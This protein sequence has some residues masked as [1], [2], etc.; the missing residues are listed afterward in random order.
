MT[1]ICHFWYIPVHIHI[2][3][4]RSVQEFGFFPDCVSYKTDLVIILD[5]STSVSGTNFETMKGFAADLLENADIDSGHV[6]VG[7]LLYSTEVSIQFY[8]REY[9][10]KSE[11]VEAISRIPYIRGST[12]TADALRT[13]WTRMFTA[14]YGDRPDAINVAVLI[15]DGLSNINS[16]RTLIEANTAKTK[17]IHIYSIGIGLEDT[18][19]ISAIATVPAAKNVFTINDFREL[20][21]LKKDVLKS[22]CLGI[23]KHI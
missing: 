15:T 19:E 12:N 22:L 7:V 17:G 20:T 10:K 23:L 21:D 9:S 5:S 13:V 14:Y 8:L 16:H 4:K 1:I 6:R 3:G 11:V 2:N 18:R